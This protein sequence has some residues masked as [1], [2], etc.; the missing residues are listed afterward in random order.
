MFVFPTLLFVTSL[1]VNKFIS[2]LPR[3]LPVFRNEQSAHHCLPLLSGDSGHS[4]NDQHQTSAGGGSLCY[5]VHDQSCHLPAPSPDVPNH[6]NQRSPAPNAHPVFAPPRPVHLFQVP[7]GPVHPLQSLAGPPPPIPIH[8]RPSFPVGIPLNQAASV[9]RV[10]NPFQAQPSSTSEQ[11]RK[12]S[13]ARMNANKPKRKPRAADRLCEEASSSNP[14]VD[15]EVSIM[16]F[17]LNVRF[18][19]SPARIFLTP[20]IRWKSIRNASNT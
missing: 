3:S 10:F 18:P 17:P 12:Q 11:N 8:T 14:V 15:R 2:A 16:L 13:A 7:P 19:Q 4:T 9:L 5:C 20:P 6:I 1:L